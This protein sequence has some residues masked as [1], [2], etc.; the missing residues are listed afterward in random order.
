MVLP[1]DRIGVYDL[2]DVA[3]DL[4]VVDVVQQAL[5]L[6]RDQAVAEQVRD[7]F[8]F[9]NV[10]HFRADELPDCVLFKSDGEC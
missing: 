3:K 5:A 1:E 2:I 8:Q 4:V 7:H 10:R 9:L 6:Q